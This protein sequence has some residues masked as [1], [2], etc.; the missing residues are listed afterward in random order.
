MSLMMRNKKYLLIV[1][2]IIFL[3]IS[4][5]IVFFKKNKKENSLIAE[6]IQAVISSGNFIS[7]NIRGV[8]ESDY[9]L[10]EKKAKVSMII[11]ED[12]SNYFSADLNKTIELIRDTF[13]R[14]VKIA[15]RPYAN[16]SFPFSIDSNLFTLCAGEQDKF[17]EARNLLIS[18]AEENSISKENFDLYIEELGLD[19]GQINNCL[20][21]ENKLKELEGM[22]IEAES[23][24]VFGSPTIF[25]GSE[26]IGGARP[27][28]NYVDNENKERDGL[29]TIINRHLEY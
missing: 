1:V 8:D 20:K 27:F 12:V 23:F 28:E 15:F 4:L 29:K 19:M 7:E 9:V 10:G 11:Y 6:D 24:E 14:Q 3:I 16:K 25:I 2:L 26:K 17:F 13:P 22:V 5:T 21:D 18:K